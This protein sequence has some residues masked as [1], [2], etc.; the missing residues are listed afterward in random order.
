MG[1]GMPIST[2]PMEPVGAFGCN[3]LDY[4]GIQ[5][6]LH[7]CP[8]NLHVQR[9]LHQPVANCKVPDCVKSCASGTPQVVYSSS[10]YMMPAAASVSAMPMTSYTTGLPMAY[11]NLEC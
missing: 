8:R 7:Y 9:R 2:Y 5:G 1:T 4:P 6:T 11:S 10:P 3:G